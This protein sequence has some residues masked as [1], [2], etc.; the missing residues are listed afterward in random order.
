MTGTLLRREGRDTG[1]EY[2]MPC[3]NKSRDWSAINTS[4][5]IQ[6]IA[7]KPPEVE[8]RQR[9]MLSQGFRRAWTCQHHDFGLLTSRIVRQ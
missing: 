7:G 5:G 3:D 1:N 8:K 6:G 4:Q 2:F 9:R